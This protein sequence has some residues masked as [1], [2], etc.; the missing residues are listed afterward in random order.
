MCRPDLP[1]GL[2]PRGRLREVDVDVRR[3]SL[4]QP[5][6]HNVRGI[7]TDDQQIGE[8]GTGGFPGDLN[9][10]IVPQLESNPSSAV[11]VCFGLLHDPVA[12]P[13]ANLHLDR[14]RH[15]DAQQRAYPKATS[16]GQR[17]PHGAPCS[18]GGSRSA[19]SQSC[20][21]E[22]RLQHFRKTGSVAQP[23][24]SEVD[25]APHRLGEPR[26]RPRPGRRGV[27]KVGDRLGIPLQFLPSV[28]DE[29]IDGL[30]GAGPCMASRRATLQQL[31][32]ALQ[33]LPCTLP[34]TQHRP[35]LSKQELRARIQGRIQVWRQLLRRPTA[36]R[37]HLEA[38]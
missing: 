8:I 9:A 38:R 20:T 7:S 18:G 23:R 32:G 5:P 26:H 10:P 31:L 24:I 15:G 14:H 37:S 30:Q 33:G 28:C 19:A 11:S 4:R 35:R 25:E 2:V 13:G 27:Q 22:L 3:Q 16:S 36:S 21:V 1:T 6:G 34:V 12:G 17:G 29:Q